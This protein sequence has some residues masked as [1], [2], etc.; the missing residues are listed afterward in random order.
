MLWLLG[1]QNLASIPLPLLDSLEPEAWLQIGT[2]T[3]TRHQGHSTDQEQ[4][5]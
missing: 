4:V 3:H 5:S 2:T 1:V